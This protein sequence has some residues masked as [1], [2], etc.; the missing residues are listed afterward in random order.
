M[1]LAARKHTAM[2]AA[3]DSLRQIG[4]FLDGFSLEATRPSAQDIGELRDAAPA[5]TAVYLS[6]LPKR[7]V[8]EAVGFAVALRKAGFEPVPHLAAR[9][10]TSREILDGLL[11]RLVAQ[12]HVRRVLVVAGDRDSAAGTFGNALDV[13]ESGLLQKHGISEI[14]ISAYPEGHPRLSPDTLNRAMAAKVAAAESSGLRVHLVT[15]FGFDARY[16]L[17]CIEKLRDDGFDQPIRIGMAGPTDITTLL[18]FAKRCGVRAS[19]HGAARQAGLVTRLFGAS[20]PDDIVR[21][22]APVASGEYGDVQAHFF[23]FG[24]V[25]ASARWAAAAARGEIALDRAGGFQVLPPK[26]SRAR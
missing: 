26:P 17:R 2:T 25:A 11:A 20:A 13:I 8:D 16:I 10:F 18:R 23:S 7:P 9:N 22:L 5:G 24:G 3:G 21:A 1:T 14:G 15:Q 19:V 4:Q 12:A 6:A